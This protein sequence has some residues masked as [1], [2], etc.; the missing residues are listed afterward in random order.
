MVSPGD[1]AELWCK[2]DGN[3]LNPENIVWRRDGFNKER[4]VEAFNNSTAFLTI[5]NISIDDMGAFHCVANNGFG[6]D[7]SRAVFLV[8]KR[9]CFY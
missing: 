4:S 2:V 8:V 9:K 7:S 6:N 5:R 3:P 1:E